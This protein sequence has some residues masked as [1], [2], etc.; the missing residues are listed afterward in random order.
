[1]LDRS[2]AILSKD[3]GAPK[4]FVTLTQGYIAALHREVRSPAARKATTAAL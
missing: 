1:M 2:Y 4:F 3:G